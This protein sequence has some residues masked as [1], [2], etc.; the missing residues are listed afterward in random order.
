MTLTACLIVRDEEQFLDGCLTSIR[1]ITGDVV[2]VDTGSL[3]GSVDLARKH[4]CRVV[5]YAWRDDFAAARNAALQSAAG[6]WILSI[7]AD[8]RLFLQIQR[9]ELYQILDDTDCQA[10]RAPVLSHV[11]SRSKQ[12]F[13]LADERIVLFRNDPHVRFSRRVHEDL[14]ESLMARFGSRL[15]IGRIPVIVQHLGYLDHVVRDRAKHERNIRL[16]QLEIEEKGHSPWTDYCLGTEWSSR[17]RWEESADALERAVRHSG[18][19]PY[20]ELAAYTLSYCYLQ[21]GMY[22]RCAQLCDLAVQRRGERGMP[23]VLLK[24]MAKWRA[25]ASIASLLAASSAESFRSQEDC[26][27]FILA[28]Q[29]SVAELQLTMRQ[30]GEER[31]R[32]G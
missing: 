4:G 19:A 25:H 18:G 21:R 28:Y 20:W 17:G 24:E 22:D 5:D 9:D 27:A 14:S 11:G 16:L 29:Q 3:D 26:C 6:E 15:R 8:E 32:N 2:V 1:Q 23:F 31:S 12:E 10:F 13:I 30:D 7:D